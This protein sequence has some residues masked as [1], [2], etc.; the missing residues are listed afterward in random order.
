MNTGIKRLITI[1]LLLLS[2]MVLSSASKSPYY[3]KSVVIVKVYPHKLGYKIYY[4]ANDLD[5]KSIYLPNTLFEEQV[6]GERERSKVFQGYDRSYPYMTIFWKDGAF[7]H[8]K[9]YLKPDWSDLTW[10][11]LNDPDAHDESFKNA[12]LEFDF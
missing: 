4:M 1:S 2:I 3:T 5:V 10:G 7:S 8:I 9:L 11:A 6:E 12:T